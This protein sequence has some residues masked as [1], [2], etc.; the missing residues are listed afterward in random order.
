VA[1]DVGLNGDEFAWLFD[2]Q[3]QSTDESGVETGVSSGEENDILH[4]PV[5][6]AKYRSRPPYYRSGKVHLAFSCED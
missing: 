4:A 5:R 1:A 2:N 3:H 6:K